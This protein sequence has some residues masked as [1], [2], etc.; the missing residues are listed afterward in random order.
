MKEIMSELGI[1]RLGDRF[2]LIKAIRPLKN[3]VT[4]Q[5]QPLH[6]KEQQPNTLE[7]SHVKMDTMQEIEMEGNSS[8]SS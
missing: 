7:D 4:N 3:N 1:I 6:K 2:R 8:S 5:M